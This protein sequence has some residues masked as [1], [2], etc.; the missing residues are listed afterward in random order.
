[1]SSIMARFEAKVSRCPMSGCWLWTGALDDKSYGR[2]YVGDNENGNPKAEQ[3]HRV[4]YRLFVGQIPEGHEVC[5]RCD[6][7]S[8][9]NPHHLFVGTHKENMADRDAKGRGIAGQSNKTHCPRGHEYSG[10]NLYMHIRS[11]KC[12]ACNAIRQKAYRNRQ[13]QKGNA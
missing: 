2:I 10:D 3:A 7:P 4:S 11:R 9:V 12:K 13:K 1:M 8:C 5:H 6:N